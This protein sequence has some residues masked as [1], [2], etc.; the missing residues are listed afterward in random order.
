[1]Q[2]RLHY[3]LMSRVLLGTT[4]ASSV[5]SAGPPMRIAINVSVIRELQHEVL[6]VHV[7]I[8]DDGSLRY[9]SVCL[10]Q[11]ARTLHAQEHPARSGPSEACTRTQ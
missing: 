6:K 8:D 1:M 3:E 2:K 11:D 7:V 10:G 5:S 4:P 9:L